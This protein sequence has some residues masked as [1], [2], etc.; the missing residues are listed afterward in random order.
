MTGQKETQSLWTRNFT[1]I[2]VGTVISMLGNAISGFALGL[3]VLDYTDSTLLYAIYMVVYT[4]P[5]VLAPTLAGPFLDRFSRRKTIYTL[6]FT[7]AA[8]YGLVA[9]LVFCGNLSYGLFL[10]S[11]FL[12]G[13]IDSVYMVAYDSFYPL[14]ITEGNYTKAYS[15]TSV[16]ESLTLVM[17]PVSAVLYNLVGM[18]PLLVVNAVCVFLAAVMETQIDQE[19]RYTETQEGRFGLSQ[20]KKTFLEGL[21]YLWQERGLLAITAYFCISM[22][23][24]ASLETLALPYFKRNY[25]NG[26]YLYILTMGWATVGRMIGGGIHYK[27]RYPADRKFAIAW[28]VYIAIALLNGTMLYLPL[29][30]TA[31]FSLCAG[32][33]GVTSYNIRIS[34]TQSYVPDG[35]KGRFNGMFQMVTMV[36]M[37]LGQLVSGLLSEMLEERLVIALFMTL[38][39]LAALLLIGGGRAHIRPIYNREG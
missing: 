6:D 39:L 23:S 15:I 34:A 4:A 33:L 22:F 17:I 31:L 29:P 26:E 2:T 1:I 5:K 14:L 28:T 38:E 30:V 7:S 18:G 32:L 24:G 20:Y 12:L 10:G 25:V 27:I 36:G 19:E 21:S 3:M 8:L 35:R 11:C 16:L 9:W 37:L 13:I